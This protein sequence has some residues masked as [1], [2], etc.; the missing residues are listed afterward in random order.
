M[1]GNDKGI[2]F[3]A[4]S[5]TTS[6][7]MVRQGTVWIREINRQRVCDGF[8]NTVAAERRTGDGGDV[9]ALLIEDGGDHRAFCP[10]SFRRP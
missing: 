1:A 3:F 10:S 4:G 6:I 9:N 2:L 8:N 7:S 5:A